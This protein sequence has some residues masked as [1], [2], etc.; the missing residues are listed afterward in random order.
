MRVSLSWLGEFV[1][2][3]EDPLDIARTLTSIGLKVEKVEDRGREVSGVVV[4]EVREVL[5]H[6]NADK[7][8][9]VDVDAGDAGPVRVVCGAR[10]FSPG[11]KVPLARPGGSLPGVPKFE[12][13][14]IRGELSDGMLCS[15]RDLGMSESH[16][17]II[18]LP[19][20]SLVGSDVA[21]LLGMKDVVLEL[22]V[23]PNRPDE[24]SLLGVARE[25]AAAFGGEVRIPEVTL[26]SD[27]ARASE[28]VTV[29]IRDLDGCPRYL[30]V[31]IRGVRVGPSPQW[32]QA[33][34]TA[35]G[36]RP[37]SNVV[38]ASNYALLVSG[39]PMH[40]FDLAKIEGQT[41]VVRRA[42]E[43]EKLQTLDGI[44]RILDPE[45]LV[46]ADA[47][48][49]I[50]IAGVMGGMDSE[51]SDETVDIV[52]E[53]A[54]FDPRSIFRTA[55]R[56]S[57]RTE[58]SARFERGADPDGAAWAAR[59]V[60]ALILE[61]AGGNLAADPID[62]YPNA[63]P[64]PRIEMRVE[65]ARSILALDLG[66]EE[67][68]HALSRLGVKVDQV[69]G[70]IHAEP[71][72][73]R[74]D[75]VGEEDLIEEVARMTGYDRIPST[76]PQGSG[77]VGTLPPLERNSRK[78]KRILTGAGLHEAWSSILI[79]PA[80]IERVG[81]KDSDPRAN[82]VRLANP[83]TNEESILR[84]SLIPG[85]VRAVAHNFARRSLDVRLFEIGRCF[86]PS[87]ETLPEEPLRIG[88]ALGGLSSSTWHV[89][90]RVVD[91]Y[92]LKGAVETLLGGL[93]V[94]DW[95][96]V[97]KADPIL[98]PARAAAVLVSGVEAGII[99]ELSP[100][101]VRMWDIAY[102]PCVG[103]IDYSALIAAV[104]PPEQFVESGRFPASLLDI[105]I[106][107]G[108]EVL[109]GEV[110]RTVERVGGDLLESARLFDVYRGEQVGGGSK[111]LA[112]ALSF[113]SP[114]RTLTDAE[115]IGLRDEIARA[116]TE[117]HGGSI[118]V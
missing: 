95:A 63:I 34:L 55:Q 97:P 15:E 3:P 39:H 81:I 37:I 87:E 114:D 29:D 65:R 51:V 74:R 77:R 43:G 93:G 76:V 56:H 41:I 103:E 25:A 105:A 80:D 106:V 99:G 31:V 117:E 96:I 21:E 23:T 13:R 83:L 20:D 7:L 5:Q 64:L 17:G 27:E 42:S 52:V 82:V 22:E 111:S 47:S 46:I 24:M 50:G 88:I 86:V 9:L 89:P 67:M 66:A 78:I 75:L 10:N 71:P 70:S 110:V 107:V 90:G 60:S 2:L 92:D 115:T 91:F 57:L 94:R 44:E 85:L 38:D 16:E 100:D 33:R 6:P 112:I 14:R 28:F 18:I 62:V 36:I 35:S 113:R 19:S 1:D 102:P 118:R 84:P 69:N 68:M 98:H 32:V 48:N 116:I 59:Y 11:D 58:A 79:G 72:P 45:D 4:A 101:S 40:A 104:E 8:V 73:W 53:S 30:A 108:E 49:P 54:Y 61:W 109:A 12:A 26:V